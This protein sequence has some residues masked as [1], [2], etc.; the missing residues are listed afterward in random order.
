MPP[1][2][3]ALADRAREEFVGMDSPLDRIKFMWTWMAERNPMVR[4]S[5]PPCGRQA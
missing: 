5:C 1:F 2:S 4:T 3:A